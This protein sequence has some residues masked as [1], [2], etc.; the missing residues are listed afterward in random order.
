MHQFASR[1][2]DLLLPSLCLA[3]DEAV[4]G[5]IALCGTCWG[6]IHF[7]AK[8]YCPCC[9]APFETPVGDGMLCA[10]CIAEPPEFAS[11]R[12]A[13]LYDDASRNIILG[14]KHG[15]RT[16]SAN[17]LAGWMQRAG[18]ELLAQTDIIMP[19][20][21][22]RWGLFKRR[23]N[24]SALLALRLGKLS[25]KR[26]MVD[27]LN[28]IRATP[29]QGHLKRKERADNVKGAFTVTADVKAKHILL[30]D[31]VVTTGSTVN[32]CAKVLKQAGAASVTVLTLAR[33]RSSV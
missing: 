30:I 21:L 18:P 13:M 3:C 17:V 4:A 5:G 32:E 26:V 8:P 16:H 23:Y 1:A 20:P 9:G 15:D 33:A 29:A 14:F 12:A 24:Q 2:L 25:G 6:K 10:G 27:G 11:S 22:H 19:V 31:D 28:R 7:I